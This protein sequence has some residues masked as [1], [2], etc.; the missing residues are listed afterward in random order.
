MTGDTVAGHSLGPIGRLGRL[1]ADNRRAVFAIWAVV[2][3]G[4]GFL[5]PRVEHALSGAGWEALGSESVSVRE[6]VD[7]EFGGAGAYGLQ[8]AVHS[9]R[10]AVEDRRFLRTLAAVERTLAGESAVGTVVPRQP[11]V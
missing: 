11:G 9:E 4:L 8:V 7:S 10:L 2:A 3:V 1:A 5:A 6:Q